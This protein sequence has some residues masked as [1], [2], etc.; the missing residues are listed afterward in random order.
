MPKGCQE[1]LLCLSV[2]GN[3]ILIVVLDP[4]SCRLHL[5]TS[6]KPLVQ[7]ILHEDQWKNPVW[8]PSEAGQILE[9]DRFPNSSI[10]IPIFINSLLPHLFLQMPFYK[11]LSL[12]YCYNICVFWVFMK[13]MSQYWAWMPQIMNTL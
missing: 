5:I 12:M 11:N 13:A 2:S 8:T 6:M 10:K 9:V 1:Q 7:N 4:I 3:I